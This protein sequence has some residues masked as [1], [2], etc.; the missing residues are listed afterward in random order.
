VCRYIV[1]IRPEKKVVDGD[2]PLKGHLTPSPFVS[3]QIRSLLKNGS[4][5]MIDRNEN[6]KFSLITDWRIN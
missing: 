5:A 1:P 4:Q 3:L 2:T 6:I